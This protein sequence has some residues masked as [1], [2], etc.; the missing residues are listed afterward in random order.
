M[1]PYHL[2]KVLDSYFVY[3]CST[4]Q[5]Y[6][7]DE[8]TSDLLL[9]AL[10]LP[11][12]EAAN[13]LELSGKYSHAD[14]KSVCREIKFLF[15]HGLADAPHPYISLSQ[16]KKILKNTDLSGEVCEIHLILAENCNLACRYCYC[17]KSNP[18]HCQKLMP[19]EVARK[20]VD[21]LFAQKSHDLNIT[22]FG[23]E[24][25]LN[26][27]VLDDIMAYSKQCNHDHARKVSYSLTT[28]ATLLDGKTIDYIVKD[29]FGL[30]VSLDG[31]KELHDAQCP[32][33]SGN[34]TYDR[35]TANIRKI[36]KRRPVGV[37][38]TMIHPL[39]NLRKLIDFF[40]KF[41]FNSMVLGM[42]SNRQDT[43]N[44]CD[45]TGEDLAESVRQHEQLLPWMLSYLRQ[46]KRPPYFLHERWYDAIRNGE[47][48]ASPHPCAC[49]AGTRV[50]AVDTKG[51]FYPCS[52]FVGLKKW[53]IGSLAKGLDLDKVKEQWGKYVTAISRH[54]GKCWAYPVCHGPCIWEC[55]LENGEIKFDPKFCH[56]NA[57]SIEHAAYLTLKTQENLPEDSNSTS[58]EC[59]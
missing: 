4:C 44:E 59:L 1:K 54:C 28:N 11:L 49:G 20:A 16:S 24:P 37:R 3:D 48:T 18:V 19:V 10:R 47:A 23:G 43:P 41:G 56:F 38:A 31:P 42:A 35:A 51:N 55:A 36:M 2:F 34:G 22:Y 50:I 32:D 45:L 40:V 27:K 39:P 30:M 6:E 8:L 52:K 33:K 26:K 53:R 29:N 21:F 12:S 17:A 58:A 57:K 14:I 46:A 5:F 15:R 25:L 9:L 7:I 13:A